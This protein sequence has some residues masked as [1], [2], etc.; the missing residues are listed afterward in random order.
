MAKTITI[1]TPMVGSEEM[2]QFVADKIA[3]EIAA[4]NTSGTEIKT[5]DEA[6][7]TRTIQ[8]EW[9]SVPAAE[10]WVAFM[11]TSPQPPISAT[12]EP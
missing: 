9:V 4:G 6:N 8:R 3:L 11:E 12:I 7:N 5:T 2:K 1:Y 10:S